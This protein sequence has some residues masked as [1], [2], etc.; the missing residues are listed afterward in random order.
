MSPVH[1]WHSS[2]W[3]ARCGS[4]AASVADEWLDMCAVRWRRYEGQL[5]AL[6]MQLQLL[7]EQ[8]PPPPQP[9]ATVAEGTPPEPGS[10]VKKALGGVQLS[11]AAAMAA[12]DDDALRFQQYE[13]VSS[14]LQQQMATLQEAVVAAQAEAAAATAAAEAAR[15]KADAIASAR[16]ASVGASAQRTQQLGLLVAAKDAHEKAIEQLERTVAAGQKASV[17]KGSDKAVTAKF[18]KAIAAQGER[19]QK[20]IA[21]QETKLRGLLDKVTAASTK[22][23]NELQKSTAKSHDAQTAR[24]AEL[25]KAAAAQSEQLRQTG[26]ELSIVDS[27]VSELQIM[28]AQ[29][30]SPPDTCSDAH[31]GRTTALE[32]RFTA[33]EQSVAAQ[34]QTLEKAS[35]EQWAAALPRTGGDDDAAAFD[36]G[37]GSVDSPAACEQGRLAQELQALRAD[38]EDGQVEIGRRCAQLEAV[39]QEVAERSKQHDELL[40]RLGEAASAAQA[41]A[42]SVASAR[43]AGARASEKRTQQLET[44]V[45]AKGTHDQAIAEL[46]KAVVAGQ[47]ASAKLEK[48]STAQEQK[49]DKAVTSLDQKFDKTVTV[50]SERLQKAIASQETKLRGLLD[51]AT[52]ASTKQYTELQKSSSG[53]AEQLKKEIAAQGEQLQQQ[54]VTQVQHLEQGTSATMQR[55]EQVTLSTMRRQLDVNMEKL[56]ALEGSVERRRKTEEEFRAQLIDLR[57]RTETAL[58]E[59]LESLAQRMSEAEDQVSRQV[60]SELAPLREGLSAQLKVELEEHVMQHCEKAVSS[61][62]TTFSAEV[63]EKLASQQTAMDERLASCVTQTQWEGQ[64]AEAAQAAN[65]T[66]SELTALAEKERDASTSAVDGLRQELTDS[67]SMLQGTLNQIAAIMKPKFD[68]LDQSAAKLQTVGE[69]VNQSQTI[70]RMMEET[71]TDLQTRYAATLCSMATCGCVLLVHRLI[72]VAASLSWWL[73][74]LDRPSSLE[75]VE[76]QLH[77]LDADARAAAK[78]IVEPFRIDIPQAMIRQ[79]ASGK[80]YAVYQFDVRR[81][82]SRWLAQTLD[83]AD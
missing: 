60:A 7:Q 8:P 71:Q 15:A 27:R 30:T 50:Q 81:R 21:S 24:S 3:L 76:G 17:A 4:G 43:Q 22:Q 80:K 25:Q 36:G 63:G 34:L 46:E 37:D 10:T 32:S 33:F 1:G 66:R 72:V 62:V 26:L 57:E 73:C 41:K 59:G 5:Q 54:I 55:L 42:D 29:T 11:P 49:F 39:S 53:Q 64:C 48:A 65:T 83:R 44:L 12:D 52:A 68:V 20:A 79:P 38:V 70:L 2:A 56:G 19:L 28:V 82:P 75:V 23:Y 61:Q 69:E 77:K 18:D 67:T 9:Q 31:N 74:V 78:D 58:H 40:S 35:K 16:Q 14:M 45:A 6:Q 13:D 51:K 47:K